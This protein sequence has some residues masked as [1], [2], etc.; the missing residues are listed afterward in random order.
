MARIVW[1]REALRNLDLI[2]D[3]MLD[4]AP[5]SAG[6]LVA[7]LVDAIEPVASFPRMGRVVP[8]FGVENLR[9]LVIDNFRIVYEIDGE[10][11]YVLSV[12]HAAMDVASRLRD[13]G[14]RSS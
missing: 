12:F 5:A 14:E 11:V 8:E 9:E 7:R 4:V 2:G 13:P 3:Y 1:T 10:A 6:P